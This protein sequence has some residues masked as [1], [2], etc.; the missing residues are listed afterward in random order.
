MQAAS[1]ARTAAASVE[2]DWV[3]DVK[4][5]GIDGAKLAAEA[6]EAIARYAK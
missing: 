6:R 5:K 4:S 3:N 2:S 1:G